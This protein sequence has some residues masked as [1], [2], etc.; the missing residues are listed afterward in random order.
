M[1]ENTDL[2]SQIEELCKA[3]SI[4]Y[5]FITNVEK[6]K[7]VIIDNIFWLFDTNVDMDN[8]EC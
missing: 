1:T 8:I 2:K 5:H 3:N 7:I 4:Q 6:D